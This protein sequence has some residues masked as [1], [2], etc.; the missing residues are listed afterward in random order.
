MVVIAGIVAGNI[1][2]TGWVQTYVPSP[3]LGRVS[4]SVQVVNFGAMPLGAVLAGAIATAIG[5][6]PTLWIL[7][8]ALIA[9]SLILL[10]GPLK[11]MRDLPT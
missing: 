2:W 5:V 6:R 10:V 3:L 8:V 4:T 11:T 7:M 1:I 9:S